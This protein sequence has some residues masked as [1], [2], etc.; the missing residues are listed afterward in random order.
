MMPMDH[1]DIRSRTIAIARAGQPICSHMLS[2]LKRTGSPWKKRA[3]ISAFIDTRLK[4]NKIAIPIVD[5]PHLWKLCEVF[6]SQPRRVPGDRLFGHRHDGFCSRMQL[7][8]ESSSLKA[9]TMRMLNF[10]SSCY[11]RTPYPTLQKKREGWGTPFI[12]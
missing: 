8:Y 1:I 3:A 6:F 5:A 4:F 10:K 9:L 7:P 11:S 2:K 12:S